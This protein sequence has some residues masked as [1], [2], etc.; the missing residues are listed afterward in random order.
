MSSWRLSRYTVVF[1]NTRGDAIFHNSFMGALAVVPAEQFNEI[2]SRLDNKITLSEQSSLTLRE[3]CQNRFF[4]PAEIDEKS[5]VSE[6]LRQESQGT[7]F[8]IIILPHENCNFRCV[9]C[10]ETHQR[11]RM[12]PAVVNGLKRLVDNKAAAIKSLSIRWF[13]GEP[14]LAAD[15]IDDLSASFLASCEKHGIL[16]RSHMTTNAYLLTPAVF[17]RLINN[18]IRDYQITLDGPEPCHDKTRV[19][20]GG[21]KTFRTIFNNLVH[22]QQSGHDF[23]V[24]LRINFN[25]YSIPLMDDF[26]GELSQIFGND[27]R[28]GLYLRPIGKY[29]GPND[30]NIE[31]C[32]PSIAKVI[33]M[34]LSQNYLPHGYL[35]RLVKKS[36]QSHGQV[37]YAAKPN[38]IVVGSDG[39]IY[40]CSVS[41][42]DA[43]NQVGRLRPDGTLDIDLS[44]WEQ[45]VNNRLEENHICASCPVYPICQG[46]YCPRSSIR[47]QKPVCPMTRTTYA[48]LVQLAAAS[49]AR[50]Q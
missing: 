25:D 3:L 37:C 41:F 40:K 13:G 43:N 36:L 18:Q 21:G 6:V 17:E 14:L 16:Y 8:D 26:F 29:G 45:W 24:S 9:Y 12:E 31:V 10:Y 47:E 48:Q 28:F 1:R 11:G 27:R 50:F 38:S 4:F 2:E 49:T 5:Y 32:D 19:L 22:M 23:T 35:D 44:R 46:K 30:A 15:I 20:A 33:E 7:D 39:T 42:Q 34:E